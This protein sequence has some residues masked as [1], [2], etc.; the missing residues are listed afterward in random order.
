M[1][2]PS[3]PLFTDA[4]IAD[5]GHLTA[6][7]TGAYMLLLMMA[8][9]S[10]GCR[11]PDDDVKLARWARC[12]ARVW[13]QTKPVVMEFW[14][15]DAEG[16]WT[17][18]RLASEYRTVSERAER[19]R[20]NG[21]HGGRHKPL[22][23]NEADNPAGS[24]S[25][26]QKKAP[27]P[28]PIEDTNVSSND[29]PKRKRSRTPYSDRFE[30][31]WS[32]YPTDALMSKKKAAEAFARLDDDEQQ[33]IIASLPA[34]RS[35]C[36]AHPDYRPVHAV[37]YI[38]QGRH[39]GFLKVAQASASRVWVAE[40]SPQWAAWQQVKKTPVTENRE[41]RNERGWYFPSE[42]PPERAAA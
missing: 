16:Y 5:T 39:D 23:N 41:R 28:N 18:K 10:P 4:F 13:R 21:Q 22:K 17:Q 24:V 1:S 30:A 26:S 40:G 31:F 20:L 7:Q 32:E 29:S 33:Q 35:Y 36:Q 42:W 2:F 27:N 14:T 19:A 3:L 12:D 15:L 25:V 34:F 9:R 8:W 11:L 38:T 37:R 6:H